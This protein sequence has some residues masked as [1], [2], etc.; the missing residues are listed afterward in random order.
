MITPETLLRI[1]VISATRSSEVISGQRYVGATLGERLGA[2]VGFF[3]GEVEGDR[4]GERVGGFVGAGS[5]GIGFVE[6]RFIPAFVSDEAD[7]T[8]SALIGEPLNRLFKSEDDR[9]RCNVLRTR[10][11]G[12]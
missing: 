10:R 12:P 9:L 11:S 5:G 6:Y 7:K 3:V 2:L 8:S 4:L 1:S